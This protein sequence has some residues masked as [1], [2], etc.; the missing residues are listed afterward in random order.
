MSWRTREEEEEE[1]KSLLFL[2]PVLCTVQYTAHTHA[3]YIFLELCVCVCVCV[4]VYST[5]LLLLLKEVKK[6]KS[7]G[8]VPEVTPCSHIVVHFCAEVTTAV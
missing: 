1:D 4:W 7:F 2:C 8:C 6:K 5:E 3:P